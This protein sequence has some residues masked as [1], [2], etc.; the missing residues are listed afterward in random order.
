MTPQTNKS[1]VS[2]VRFNFCFF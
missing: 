2:V 1:K